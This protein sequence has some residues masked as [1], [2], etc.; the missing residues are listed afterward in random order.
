MN[1]PYCNAELMHEDSFGTLDFINGR[2][3]NGKRGDIYKCPNSNGFES[4]YDC[5]Y[6][7]KEIDE[8]LESL[9]YESYED[10]ICENQHGNGFY[11]TYENSDFLREG[12]PC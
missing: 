1:C 2:D 11:Y 6:Y 12:Y 10:V 4:E 5:K 3:R 7:L 9:G 8:T